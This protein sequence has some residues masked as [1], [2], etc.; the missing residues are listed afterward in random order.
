MPPLFSRSQIGFITIAVNFTVCVL[1]A[2]AQSKTEPAKDADA[3]KAIQSG[4]DWLAR[5]QEKDGGWSFDGS[6]KDRI[7][8]TGMVLLPFLNSGEGPTT[9]VKYKLTV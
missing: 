4:L 5:K 3:E 8:A 9:G 1:P 7:A 2:V 6:S